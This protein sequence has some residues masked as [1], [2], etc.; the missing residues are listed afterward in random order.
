MLYLYT[1]MML[2]W[3]LDQDTQSHFRRYLD[4][5]INKRKISKDLKVIVM[6]PDVRIYLSNW[7]SCELEYGMFNELRVSLPKRVLGGGI[8]HG[9]RLSIFAT[10]FSHLSIPVLIEDIHPPKYWTDED[11]MDDG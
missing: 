7:Y 6:D 4:V 5:F 1:L 2:S 11:G 8:R 10:C 3:D 9:Q